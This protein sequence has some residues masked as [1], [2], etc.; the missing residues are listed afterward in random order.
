M[1]RNNAEIE[2]E[3]RLCLPQIQDINYIQNDDKM[4]FNSMDDKLA[5]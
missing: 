3:E 2:V 4:N 5:V 1:R